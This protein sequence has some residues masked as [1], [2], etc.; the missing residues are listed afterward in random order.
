V[1]APTAGLHFTPQVLEALEQKEVGQLY[2][3]LHVS[4]GTFLPVKSKD[5]AGHDMHSEQMIVTGAIIDRLLAHSG[6]VIAVGTTSMRFLESM[7]WLGV[8]AAKGDL[9]P[10]Q[11]PGLDQFVPYQIDET[12]LP[13]PRE[14]LQA[15][16]AHL[17]ALAHDHLMAETS[18]FILP[19]YRFRI[20]RGLITNYHLPESTLMLLV[21]AFI[22]EDWRRVYEQAL[23]QGYRFLSYGD[24]SLLLP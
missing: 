5:A 8:A 12:G 21:A 14:A 4:A 9:S 22:G 24:S 20:C 13:A 1:A 2:V 17:Q 19:G 10:H 3:T 11:S 16:K 15:L 23:Q 7:Y 18:I 6:P